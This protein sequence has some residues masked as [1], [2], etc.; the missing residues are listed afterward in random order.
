MK[1]IVIVTLLF[2]AGCA[3]MIP[4]RSVEIGPGKYKLEASGN[5]FSSIP[6][7]VAKID[8]KAINLCG[9][10]KYEYADNGEFSTPNSPAYVNGVNIGASY[11]VLTRIVTC[12]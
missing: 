9:A 8:Q 3:Q 11:T 4:A 10:N 5:A 6:S 1:A 12:K 2:T 7:L